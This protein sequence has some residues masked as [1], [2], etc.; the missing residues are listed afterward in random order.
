VLFR[1]LGTY[2]ATATTGSPTRTVSGG[3][4][5]YHWTGNGSITI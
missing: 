3:Y 5:Y 1:V 4:T 2:T